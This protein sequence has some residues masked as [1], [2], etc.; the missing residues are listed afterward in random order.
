MIHPDTELRRVNETIG[1]G[2]FATR[3]IP[4]GTILYVKDPLE[5]EVTPEQ[6]EQM[7]SQYQ[8]VVNWF[9]YIDE[10]GYR[11]V[12]WDIAKYVNHRCDAN[13][14]STGYGFEIATRDIAAGE[15]ITD[16]YGIFNLPCPMQCCC[17]SRNC[18]G[19]ISGNDW[20]VFGHVWDKRA[21][22]ALRCLSQVAQPLMKFLDTEVYHDLMQYLNS[23]RNYRS[24]MGLRIPDNKAIEKIG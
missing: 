2:V 3:P 21:K 20:D 7:D 8:S 5:I 23:R 11:I 1:Y 16:E 18:R 13:S 15:E 6:F 19:L 12:S 17:G 10:R 14:I 9:S 4:K 22:D 24:L